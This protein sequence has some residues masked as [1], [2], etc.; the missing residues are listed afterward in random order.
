MQF[1]LQEKPKQ[2]LKKKEVN[3]SSRFVQATCNHKH[4]TA[5]AALAFHSLTQKTKTQ[6]THAN[7]SK[8]IYI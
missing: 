6:T 5:V 1:R 8:N 2:H 7:I 4:V 3:K